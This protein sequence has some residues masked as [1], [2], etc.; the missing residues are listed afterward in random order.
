MDRRERWE[1][2]QHQKDWRQ[3]LHDSYSGNG[4]RQGSID[5]VSGEWIRNPPNTGP[6]GTM[7]KRFFYGGTYYQQKAFPRIHPTKE[8]VERTATKPNRYHMCCK[9]ARSHI[10]IGYLRRNRDSDL[11]TAPDLLLAKG[12]TVAVCDITIAWEGSAPLSLAYHQKVAYYN[13]QPILE[14]VCKKYPGKNAVVL[15]FVLGARGTWC[16]NNIEIARL[17]SLT[18]AEKSSLINNVIGTERVY[19]DYF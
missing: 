10:G 1:Y 6:E 19:A 12:N 16:E 5:G 3:K 14:E 4:L 2:I 8:S 17:L 15:V 18:K 9:D 11:R 7:L 13:Q